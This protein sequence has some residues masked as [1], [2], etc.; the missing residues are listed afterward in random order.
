MISK[1]SYWQ[2]SNII[3]KFVFWNFLYQHPS[4]IHIFLNYYY[5]RFYKR[6]KENQTDA[7]NYVTVF[8]TPRNILWWTENFLSSLYMH[9]NE[10]TGLLPKHSKLQKSTWNGV[11]NWCASNVSFISKYCFTVLLLSISAGS[12]KSPL[13][14]VK[15][16]F[17]FILKALFILKIFK[18]LPWL[19]GHIEKTAWL[20]IQG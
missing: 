10:C 5:P 15:N 9:L 8:S 18:F 11:D 17:Y 12:L 3:I 6:K 2:F 14:M 16:A 20:E 19:F 7:W 4:K 1:G 13:K